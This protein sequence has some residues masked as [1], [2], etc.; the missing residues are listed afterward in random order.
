MGFPLLSEYPPVL[1]AILCFKNYLDE[2]GRRW[3]GEKLK[4]F[5]QRSGLFSFCSERWLEQKQACGFSLAHLSSKACHRVEGRLEDSK[6][7]SR[8]PEDPALRLCTWLGE[9]AV[10]RLPQ[11][12]PKAQIRGCGH[13]ASTSVT[14]GADNPALTLLMKYFLSQ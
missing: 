5:L 1:V 7:H 14:S 3:G 13:R 10:T 12:W 6:T 2:L 4:Q 11:R 9:D 8:E